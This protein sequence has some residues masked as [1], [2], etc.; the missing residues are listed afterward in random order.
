MSA[1]S[2]E[3][4]YQFEDGFEFACKTLFTAAGLRA[5]RQID[6][7]T[8]QT[9]YVGIQFTMGAA[10]QEYTQDKQG[11]IRDR[12]FTA[13][14]RTQIVCSRA[15]NRNELAT[16]RSLIRSI[17][18]DFARVFDEDVLNYYQIGLCAESGGSNSFDTEANEDLCDM[19]WGITF[20]IRDGAWPA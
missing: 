8:V 16:H 14:I 1:P 15:R 12:T 4:L 3:I 11:V 10:Q 9:P 13:Q 19:I 2:Y 18:Y 5:F 7:D 20:H 17:M 6:T